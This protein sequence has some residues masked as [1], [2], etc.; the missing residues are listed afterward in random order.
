MKNLGDIVTVRS[1]RLDD[2]NFI[3]SIGFIIQNIFESVV[4]LI[5]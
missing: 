5:F 4:V 2:I 3:V 1:L